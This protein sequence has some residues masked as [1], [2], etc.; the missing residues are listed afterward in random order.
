MKIMKTKIKTI[1]AI[2]ILGFVGLLNI[3]AVAG[4][5]SVKVNSNEGFPFAGTET[6]LETLATSLGYNFIGETANYDLEK[7]AQLFTT[8]VVDQEET[9]LVN[10]LNAKSEELVEAEEFTS[11][12]VDQEEAKL[13]EKVMNTIETAEVE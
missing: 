12:V 3:Q 1:T 13:L 7:E 9:K 4:S 11:W 8:W 10:K 2:C 5:N 6:G